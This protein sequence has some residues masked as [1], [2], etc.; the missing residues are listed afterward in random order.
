VGYVE[1]AKP[2][3]DV[4]YVGWWPDPL[5]PPAPF[6]V[7]ADQRQPLWVTADV[8][9]DAK[10]GIYRGE[11]VLRV[12]DA[13][14]TVPIE[15]GVRNFRLP[16]PGTLATA[17]GLYAHVLARWYVGKRPYREAFPIEDFARWCRFLGQYRLAP[18][19]IARAYIEVRRD[20][21][22]WTA[23]L[24]ALDRTVKPLAE[25]CYAPYSFCLHRLP[26]APVLRRKGAQHD[27]AAWIAR[28]KAIAAA[29]KQQ[30]LPKQVYIYGMD[31]PHEEELPFL[32]DLYRR[33]R[34]AV[35]GYPIMQTIGHPNPRKLVGLVDIWCPLI[36]RLDS[37]FYAE[38]RNAG[39]RLWTYV[40]CGP[41]PPHANF[42]ID[43]P[44][45]AHRVLF[46]QAWHHG[47]TGLLYWCVCYWNGLPN[48]A[49]GK[50]CFPETPIRLKDL[51]TY[52]S[53]KVN[54]DGVLVYPGPD[55]MPVPSVRLEIIRD[56]IED[57]EYLALL[58]RRLEQARALP[59][60]Q[61]PP[62]ALLDH[63]E[64]LC[65][66]PPT[67]SGSL[68]DYT[69]EARDILDRRRA[70]GEMLERLTQALPSAHNARP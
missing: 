38:R 32:A 65:R 1:T 49:S 31:E 39:D 63:A 20:G 17:F 70:V 47:C 35:P 10:P 13:A 48:A 7:Q 34:K 66:V 37:P 58:R 12:G 27:T 33:L 67:I 40:C 11:V 9:P 6:D 54:G 56:G 26:V 14:E 62:T 50:P 42:F 28:T 69:R 41:R 25:T 18:K 8:P 51:G 29:W 43:Q 68:T 52:K 60:A 16:R 21:D 15:L 61:R 22:Q 19:N 3:Y 55:R 30:G 5:L 4:P 23:D 57:Y 45:T 36:A 44:P 46:W 53:Y 59:E 64:E 24:S 2:R